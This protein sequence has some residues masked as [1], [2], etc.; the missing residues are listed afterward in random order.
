MLPAVAQAFKQAVQAASA[1]ICLH[2]TTDNLRRLLLLP[3]VGLARQIGVTRTRLH[4][5]AHGDGW[6]NLLRELLDAEAARRQARGAPRAGPGLHGEALSESETKAI[7][8][9]VEDGQLR[10][11]AEMTRKTKR[12]VPATAEVL[13]DLRDKHPPGT[14]DPFRRWEGA[15]PPHLAPDTITILDEMVRRLDRQAAAGLSGWTPAMVQLCYGKPEENT[16]FRQMLFQ[17]AKQILAGTA[18]AKQLLCGSRLTPLVDSQN[19]AKIR[20]VAC[21]EVFYRICMRFLLKTLGHAG[22]LLDSQLG[23]GT[24]GGVE[25]IV[26]WLSAELEAAEA[27]EAAAG[28]HGDKFLY[29][30]DFQ[31][32]FN[33]VSREAMAEAIH[34]HAPQYYRL[35]RWA[36][37][38]ATVLVVVGPEGTVHTIASAEGGR[39]GDPLL[40]LFF[41]LVLRP[42]LQELQGHVLQPGDKHKSY[43]DDVLILSSQADRLPALLALCAPPPGQTRPANGL[44]LNPA[45]TTMVPLRTVHQNPL[46]LPVLG[47]VLGPV[48][49]RRTYLQQKISKVIHTINRARHLPAQHALLLLRLCFTPELLHL[50]RTMET[51]DLQ[52]ELQSLDQA[53]QSAAEFL[54]GAPPEPPLPGLA[55]RI[56]TLPVALG[57]C[58]L[59]SYVEIRAVA[60]AAA[61]EEARHFLASR[62]E[63]LPGAAPQGP[64]EAPAA[65]PQSPA[66]QRVRVRKLYEEAI[67]ALLPGL[68]D[69]QTVAFHDNGSKLGSAWLHAI[70]RGKHLA[71]SDMQVRA[72]LGIRCLQAD[73]AGGTHCPAC[74]AELSLNH[75]EA[76]PARPLPIQTRHNSVCEALAGALRRN[77]K[78]RV[79]LEPPV[80]VHNP[81]LRRADLEGGVVD[82]GIPLDARFGLLDVKIKHVLANNAAAARAAAR[83]GVQLPDDLMPQD[84]LPFCRRQAWA[85]IEAALELTAQRCRQSYANVATPQAVIPVVIST[86]GSLH[87]EATQMIK[88]LLP[89]GEQR[90]RL[91]IEISIVLLRARAYSYC[92]L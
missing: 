49:A 67:T 68:T 1:E 32:A 15:P 11:A 52:A 48:E 89:D 13:Q 43:L 26:E 91:R 42:L 8:R 21:G 79:R 40:P 74:Q 61:K 22:A 86:G 36:Y 18:P 56:Y 33:N 57:G 25:P 35:A 2:G 27:G 87:R 3:K 47:C 16:A 17:L 14:A 65:I 46:G 84:A 78:R 31:N 53:V 23:V 81:Q 60:R 88:T 72:G 30:L 38:A 59:T 66:P 34:T 85:Q 90:R 69:E 50:L 29:A 9:K 58:G 64:L 82:G 63:T 44:I 19:P 28:D 10:K 62:G 5:L 51:L 83:A 75:Y 4:T 77:T 70:P 41:S 54:R 92:T 45:K 55:R 37:G 20:P 6:R 39:Q 73:A 76:C 24:P 80:V 71:L 7:I 12:V